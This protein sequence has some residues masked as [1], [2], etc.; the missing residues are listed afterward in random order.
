[1]LKIKRPREV[2]RKLGKLRQRRRQRSFHQGTKDLCSAMPQPSISGMDPPFGDAFQNCSFA[3]QALTSTDLLANSSDPDFMYELDRDMTCRQSPRGEIFTAGDCKDMDSVD[4]PPEVLDTDPVYSANFEQWDTYWEDLTKYTRLTSCDI[5]G[6]KEVDFLGIDD[7]SSPYQD[8]EVI[9][10]TPTLAQLNSEDSQPVSDTLYHPDLLVGQK[11]LFFPAPTMAKKTNRLNISASSA[12]SSRNPPADFAEGSQKATWPV[13][14]NTDTVA[15]AQI[16]ES[17]DYVRKAKLCISVPRRPVVECSSQQ[18]S[19]SSSAH[20]QESKSTAPLVSDTAASAANIAP[21]INSEKKALTPKREL[22]SAAGPEAGIV[23]T[24]PHK[25]HFPSTTGMETLL[26]MSGLASDMSAADKK[27]EEEHNYSL[28]LTRARL[29]G[30]VTAEMEE[31]EEEEEEEE[32]EEGDDD[33]DDEEK[34]DDDL[35]LD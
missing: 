32:Y 22:T 30:K 25:L 7:F 1:M 4:H 2:D 27:K 5:W 19:V 21:S 28:F 20:L 13:P 12:S 34:A 14:S 10:R 18:V 17:T 11:Q 9:S 8:E 16:Q 23:R 33:D 29:A 26:T 6:T 24:V 3:D 31:D 35:D 15:K